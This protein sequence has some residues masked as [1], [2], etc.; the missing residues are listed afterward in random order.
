[1]L[2]LLID[3]VHCEGYFAPLYFNRKYLEDPFFFQEDSCI[4][5]LWW[6]LID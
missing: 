5:S 3:T 2:I 4:C 1:M 6:K